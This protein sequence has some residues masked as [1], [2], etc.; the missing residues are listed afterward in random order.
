[1]S[2]LHRFEPFLVRLPEVERPRYVLLFRDRMKWVGLVLLVYF[3]LK[4][5]SL[6]G[7]SPSAVDI[8]ENVRAVMAGGFGSLISLGIGPIVSASIILQIMVGGKLIDLD[9]SKSE[10]KRIFMGTQKA[11][12]IAFTIFESAV[13]V[14]FGALP[15]A[16]HIDPATGRF[17]DMNIPEIAAK[18]VPL[19]PHEIFNLQ[20]LLIAQ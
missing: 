3:L 5:T 10:D 1:M 8:F 2:I 15:A 18:A 12:A 6:Y 11:L 13:M 7:L 20:L 14:L 16:T 19:L 9:L 4:E 17:A